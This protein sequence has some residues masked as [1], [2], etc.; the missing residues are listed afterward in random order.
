MSK[1]IQVLQNGVHAH[2]NGNFDTARK[3]YTEVLNIQPNNSQANY[4][5]GLIETKL[6]KHSAATNFFKI[7]TETNPKVEQF[8][9]SY[10]F[11][12]ADQKRFVEA[13]KMLSK[14]KENIQNNNNILKLEE[15][16]ELLIQNDQ[17]EE[18]YY[19]FKNNNDEEAM[20]EAKN[21][22]NKFP[23][24][25]LAWKILGSLYQS[26][27]NYEQS[28]QCLQIALDLAPNDPE[29]YNNLGVTLETK[30]NLKEAKV[31]F[32]K[33][34]ELNGNYGEAYFNLA[35][36]LNKVKKYEEAEFSY[37]Q[38]I[39]N[40]PDFSK[41]LNNYANFLLKQNRFEEANINFLKAISLEKNN[42]D[43]FYNYGNSLYELNKLDDAEKNIKQAIRLNPKNSKFYNNLANVLSLQNKLEEAKFHYNQ[44]IKCD[45][46][47][48]EAYSNLANTLQLE[49]NFL[50]AIKNYDKAFSLNQNID[51]LSGRLLFS[52]VK[53]CRWKDHKHKKQILIKQINA[54][55]KVIH[56]FPIQSIIDCPQIQKKVSESYSEIYFKN[57]N[58]NKILNSFKNK[59]IKIGYFSPNFNNHPVAYLVSKI[60]E[61]HNN[62]YFEIHAFS[63]KPD[64]NDEF[65]KKIKKEVDFYH[66]VFKKS[67][68]EIITLSRSLG[69]DIAVDLA[70][71]T[72]GNRTN[73]FLN[74]IAPIQIVYLG[75]LGTMGSKA[76]DYIISDKIIIPEKNKK[77]FSEKI[78][79][80]PTFQGS[81]QNQYLPVVKNKKIQRKDFNIPNKKF[82][83]GCFNT[84]YKISPELFNA[85]MNILKRV[86]KSVLVICE[87]NSQVINNLRI[88]ADK[89]KINNERLFFVKYLKKSDYLAR[90]KAVDLFLDTTPYNG[91]STVS[92]ALSVGLPVITCMGKS[93]ASRQAA[94]LLHSLNLDELITESIFDYEKLAIEL[95]LEKT[96]F[97]NLKKKLN[98]N[99]SQSLLFN[100]KSYTLNL[101]K[102]YSLVYKNFKKNIK[103]KDIYIK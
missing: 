68:K 55:K 90:Y 61:N 13:K 84:S 100:N 73:I 16:L 93:F 74:F 85:W 49:K 9:L 96:K 101:E 97:N 39:K 32:Q 5:L 17:T 81:Y 89:N 76:Y 87:E 35:N 66:N 22:T 44:A 70:G 64:T 27:K 26:N 2:Q 8:W 75:F 45:P 83:F 31:Y 3:Y 63:F 78:I 91:A 62:N 4:N 77:Y 40:N 86:E 1:L 72:R 56:P 99:L 51:Y 23:K 57:F 42:A 29:I 11:N 69:I 41:A 36:I 82:V 53:L 12:L 95:A 6:K 24:N 10:I 48:A 65:N 43:F 33:A 80:L 54:G 25:L 94:S 52:E 19:L 58:L 38:A 67:D 30:G 7:A 98:E 15:E 21:V 34:I 79:Y 102:A 28:I 18:L 20:Q 88:E 46:D 59:K 60:F 14:A 47:Y 92:D 37:K 103:P 50:E 71:Y